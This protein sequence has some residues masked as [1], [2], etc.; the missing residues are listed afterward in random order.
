MGKKT[1]VAIIM[2]AFLVL[3]MACG[4]EGKRDNSKTVA[5]PESPAGKLYGKYCAACHGVDGKLG[6]SGA[7]NLSISVLSQP[8]VVD[9][10]TKGGRL[11]APFK[12]KMTPQEIDTV[13]A[14][15]LTLRK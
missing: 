2:A 11:M 7:A 10:V 8:Q 5:N 13:A 4:G 9:V 15:T 3:Q 12:D 14:Y 1:I 6:L